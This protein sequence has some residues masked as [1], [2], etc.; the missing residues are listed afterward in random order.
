[1]LLLTGSGLTWLFFKWLSVFTNFTGVLYESSPGTQASGS[2]PR[3]PGSMGHVG[4]RVGRGLSSPQCR[5]LGPPVGVLWGA[6]RSLRSSGSPAWPAQSSASPAEVASMWQIRP[7]PRRP[8]AHEVTGLGSL[9]RGH[10][11]PGNTGGTA[12]H[13]PSCHS[14][15]CRL[16]GTAWQQA[17]GLACL[18]LGSECGCTSTPFS[19]QP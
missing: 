19:Q 1:M 18:S 10:R 16:A 6:G 8:P 2:C 7:A 4:G 9:W 14:Q 5:C 12:L 3:R 13:H 11:H 17:Q 15:E